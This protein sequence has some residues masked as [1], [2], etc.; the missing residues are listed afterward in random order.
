MFVCF[1]NEIKYNAGAAVGAFET[2]ELGAELL[3]GHSDRVI[4][5]IC[6]QIYPSV[7]IDIVVF[8]IS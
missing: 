8:S 4:T 6:I 2:F 5:P 7:F 3:R 1:T